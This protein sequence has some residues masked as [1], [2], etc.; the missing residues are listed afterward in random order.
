MYIRLLRKKKQIYFDYSIQPNTAAETHPN[1]AGG[2][3][4]KKG[5]GQNSIVFSGLVKKRSTEH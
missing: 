5:S 3:K 1:T 2:E 4:K